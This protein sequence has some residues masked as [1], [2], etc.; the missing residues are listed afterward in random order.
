MPPRRL[1]VSAIATLS[2][3]SLLLPAATHAKEGGWDF[4]TYRIRITIAIDAPGGVAE[5]LADKLPRYVER[6]IDASIF[7]AWSSTVQL[8]TGPDRSKVF[9]QIA[10][11][12]NAPPPTLPKDKDKLLLAAIRWTPESI[13]LSAREY[14]RYVQRWS[15]PLRRESRQE[16]A[17]PEQLFA[18]VW[19]SFSPLAEFEVDPKDPKRAVLKPRG[20]LLPRA[21]GAAPWSKPGDIFQPV[22]RR[23]TRGGELE[24]NGLAIV[25]WTYLETIEVKNNTI[26]SR[27][28]AASR[29]P[30]SAR[31]QGR[32]DQVAIGLRTDPDATI[33]KLHSRTAAAKPLIG[34]EVF[35]QNPGE[36]ATARIGL[37]DSA[38]QI[39]ISPAKTRIQFVLVKHGGPLLARIPVLA[40]AQHRVDIPL[41]DDDARLAA[42]ARLA[43]IREDLIDVVARRNILMSRAR[44]KI[45]KKDFAAAQDLLRALD[46]LP[47]RQQFDTTVDAAKHAIH[48]DDPQMQARINQLFDTTQTLLAQYLDI[49]P[50]NQLHDELREAQSK[51]PAQIP[52]ASGETKS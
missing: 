1:Q 5:Q 34:Y 10:A 44:Q 19:Q 49:R 52:K 8:A 30:F 9:T 25:P 2:L 37:T 42:E 7:P 32:V 28:Q 13:E 41:P 39:Q 22:F 16:A 6:R 17:V 23:T 26:A 12:P 38:G 29:R 33:L 21:A 46:D 35:S 40:G 45:D 15:V 11:P 24:K 31:R 20:A 3:A 14:D 51:S 18:L 50:I 4:E 27:I 43:A 47:T 48:S 36:E